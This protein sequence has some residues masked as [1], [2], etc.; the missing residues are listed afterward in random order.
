MHSR[1]PSLSSPDTDFW[2]GA[3]V[4]S[5]IPK[6]SVSSLNKVDEHGY[7][8]EAQTR[9]SPLATAT[10]SETSAGSSRSR[11]TS[12][13]P[14]QADPTINFMPTVGGHSRNGSAGS[15]YHPAPGFQTRTDWRQSS[16]SSLS[17]AAGS[18]GVT[19]TGK[20]VSVQMPKRLG[21]PEQNDFFGPGGS[22]SY[23]PRV[24]SG[25]TRWREGTSNL[26]RVAPRLT[27]SADLQAPNVAHAR[28]PSTLSVNSPAVSTSGQG[29]SE[30]GHSDSEQA[31]RR[32]K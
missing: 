19:H 7:D 20:L 21:T 30:N 11:T 1:Q 17:S 27:L 18:Y 8:L 3:P 26:L 9:P 13:Y 6:S 10:P 16:I 5:I 2:S 4:P 14:T 24:P 23:K 25:I 28:T 15:R 22:G 29:S 31:L 32:D 12:P